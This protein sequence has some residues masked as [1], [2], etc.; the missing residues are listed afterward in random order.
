MNVEEQNTPQQSTPRPF[1][2]IPGLWLR[3]GQM[4]ETF[5]RSEIS[6]TSKLNTFKSVLILSIA[7]G[8]LEFFLIIVTKSSGSLKEFAESAQIGGGT[9]LGI[10]IFYVLLGLI[11]VP[12][13]FYMGNGVIYAWAEFFGGKG[14]FRDQAYL[15]SLYQVPLNI[16]YEIVAYFPSVPQIGSFLSRSLS[17]MFLI[18]S[19]IFTVRSIKIVHSFSTGRAIATVLATYFLLIIPLNIIRI[20][21]ISK[22]VE[23]TIFP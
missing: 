11:I 17:L 12:S 2:E 10:G 4:T 19:I 1:R 8:L 7:I 13:V 15:N 3:F 22:A 23:G 5:F 20:L 14:K 18:V 9:V 16:I 6:R 21:I